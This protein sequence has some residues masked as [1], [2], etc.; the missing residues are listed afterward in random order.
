M[1]I[2]IGKTSLGVDISWNY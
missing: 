2:I 1:Y